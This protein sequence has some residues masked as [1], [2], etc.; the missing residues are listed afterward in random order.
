MSRF[1]YS[2]HHLH[3]AT[4][5]TTQDHSPSITVTLN[6]SPPTYHQS[7]PDNI[8][9]LT[10]TATL[11]PTTAKEPIT[12]LTYSTIFNPPLALKRH[13]FFA[14]DITENSETPK[15][16]N[17]EITKG[18][19]RAAL[20]RRKSRSDERFYITFHP[21]VEHTISV[22]FNT[23][24]RQ[25]A[26]HSLSNGEVGEKGFRAGHSYRLGVADE[27]RDIQTWWWGTRDDVL[28]EV[29]GPVKDVS[30]IEGKGNVRV[31]AGVAEF[32]VEG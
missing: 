18:P 30:R 8:P 27:G 7:N 17:L 4:M 31:V 19:K 16:I 10:I 21:G 13:N 26:S 14:F 1:H 3:Q 11:D 5:N 25:P 6:I 28:D 2:F 20:R 12:I 24:R 23:A 22:P 9:E 32:A 15:R 29:D